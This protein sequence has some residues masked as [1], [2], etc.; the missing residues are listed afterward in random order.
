[1]RPSPS[2]AGFSLIEA[3]VVLAIGGMALAII[4][5]IG[6]KAG[7]TG[8][9][10]GRRALAAADL[11]IAISD[12]RAIIRSIALRPPETFDPKIDHPITG[13]ARRFEADI[14]ALRATQCM[15]LGWAGRVVL[16]V[17]SVGPARQLV[18][19]AGDRR[20]MLLSTTDREAQLSYS[21]DGVNWSDFYRTEVQTPG[22]G[23]ILSTQLF[24]RFRGG[25]LDVM[26][27]TDSGRPQAWVRT[28]GPI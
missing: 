11:D 17:E 10:L 18:C 22:S 14:V 24:V 27:V 13:E 26:D 23:E 3:L 8:F 6:I 19:E 7:D 21:R 16:M 1:M 4:F 20:I 5:S 2:R 9:Q 15:P 12:T 28:D 25:A